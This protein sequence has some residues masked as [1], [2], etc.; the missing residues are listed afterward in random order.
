MLHIHH[1]IIYHPL[2]NKTHSEC[3]G[4]DTTAPSISPGPMTSSVVSTPSSIGEGKVCTLCDAGEKLGSVVSISY[5]TQSTTCGNLDI[6]LGLESILST[7][8][9]CS[10]VRNAYRQS[11][12]QEQ[13]QL[14][15]TSSGV[16]LDLMKENTVRQGGYEATCQEIGS[17][18][19]DY[20]SGERMCA[21]AKT[22]L[23]DQ[24]CYR[25]CSLCSTGTMSTEWYK[26]VIFQGLSTTCLGL[27]YLLR[28]ERVSDGSYQCSELQNQYMSQCCR[29]SATAC[30]LC[31]SDKTIYKMHANKDVTELLL[32]TTCAAVSNSLTRLDKSDQQCTQR[33]EALF[34]QCCELGSVV[35]LDNESNNQGGVG[36]GATNTATG[37]NSGNSLGVARSPTT[38]PTPTR[39]ENPGSV[40]GPS[41]A[42]NT[43]T[44]PN[45]WGLSDNNMSW[46]E[47][48]DAKKNVPE[49]C[50]ISFALSA[51]IAACI[52]SSL[53]FVFV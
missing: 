22:Q 31:S 40:I 36:S 44:T 52:L 45:A 13:C 25:Q 35:V 49:S 51:S 33:K 34:G 11:C 7:S 2:L 32:K 17:M 10:S 18:L 8:G 12:C 46:V 14:C 21:D 6:M 37:L 50:G 24:C 4:R 28:N 47:I 38:K 53:V 9:T 1:I 29:A 5:K 41:T 48:W 3:D 27:D 26:A 39:V 15:Q 43:P 19:S 30:V 20:S 23:S 42:T 16:L